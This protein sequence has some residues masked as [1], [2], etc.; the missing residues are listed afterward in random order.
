MV[1]NHRRLKSFLY[2]ATSL[3]LAIGVF[4]WL[5]AHVTW[6]QVADLILSIH[7][8]LLGL[9]FVLSMAMQIVRT[10]RYRVVL[11]SVGQTPGFFRL[12]L[13]VLV[14]GLCVDLLPARTGELVYIYLLRAKL[15]VEL[16]AATASFALAFLFDLTALAPL[17]VAA[18]LLAGTGIPFSPWVLAAAGGLLLL[19][20]LALRLLPA[21][22]RLG[23]RLCPPAP[24]EPR[25]SAAGPATSW[26]PPI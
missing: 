15:G 8:P 4:S 17:L 26:P 16:G 6:R 2:I 5:L 21:A 3:L 9:F 7:L 18:L 24:A 11:K 19:A 20:L 23:F 25:V 14:R 12:F 10:L 22:L 1:A 13:V